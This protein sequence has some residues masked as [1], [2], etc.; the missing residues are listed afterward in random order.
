MGLALTKVSVA[1]ALMSATCTYQYGQVAQVALATSSLA[2][3]A[4]PHSVTEALR[5]K[6]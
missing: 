3:C 1:L 4:G 2:V 6:L 5:G